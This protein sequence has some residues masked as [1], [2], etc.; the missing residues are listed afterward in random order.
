MFWERDISNHDE[1]QMSII[2]WELP[3]TF[4]I[5]VYDR[6]EVKAL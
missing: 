6:M 1:Q 3:L 5:L 2:Q 4:G